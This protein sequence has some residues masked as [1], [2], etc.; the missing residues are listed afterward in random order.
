VKDYYKDDY[1]SVGLWD[2]KIKG[3]VLDKKKEIIGK[4]FT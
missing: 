1:Y 2:G 4:H 3:Y